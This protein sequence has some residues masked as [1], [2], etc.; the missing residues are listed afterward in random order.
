MKL[1]IL[2]LSATC[3]ATYLMSSCA[4]N[5]DSYGSSSLPISREVY[6]IAGQVTDLEGKGIANVEVDVN[7]KDAKLQGKDVRTDAN[8][9]YRLEVKEK[10]IYKLKFEEDGYIDHTVEVDATDLG[11]YSSELWVSITLAQPVTFTMTD[12]EMNIVATPAEVG[13]TVQPTED[14]PYVSM[15]IPAKVI[16]GGKKFEVAYFNYP[17]QPAVSRASQSL[18]VNVAGLY[19]KSGHKKY[20]NPGIILTA[21]PQT[22]VFFPS[23]ILATPTTIMGTVPMK[24]GLYTD[25]ITRPGEWAFLGTTQLTAGTLQSEEILSGSIDNVTATTALKGDTSITCK[26]QTGWEVTSCTPD[27][28]TDY[29]TDL[30]AQLKGS[31]AGALQQSRT[32]VL[33]VPAASMLEVTGSQLSRSNTYAFSLVNRAG[34]PIE[35]SITINEYIGLGTAYTVV[36]EQH[37]GGSEK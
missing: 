34:E 8:G 21:A 9:Y 13:T 37:P 33:N 3:G 4:D 23:L 11:D 30:I 36:T 22:T 19:L 5:I 26:F 32:L 20:G 1:P 27:T 16:G 25:T 7:G 6:Y 12:A 10:K 15:T 29:L 35:A 31:E 2:L 17:I 14:E 18:Y 24:E 28:L